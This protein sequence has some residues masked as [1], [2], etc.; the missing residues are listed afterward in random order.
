[1]TFSFFNSRR[2]LIEGISELSPE[3]LL[4][5]INRFGFFAVLMKNFIC[6]KWKIHTTEIYEG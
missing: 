2:I 6:R 3:N 4:Y 1:M 5:H